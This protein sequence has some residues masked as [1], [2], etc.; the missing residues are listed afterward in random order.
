MYIS[1]GQQDNTTVFTEVFGQDGKTCPLIVKNQD[2]RL[3][4]TLNNP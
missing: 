3:L 4:R 1:S 2:S